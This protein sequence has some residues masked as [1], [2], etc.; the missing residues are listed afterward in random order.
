MDL[1]AIGG[2]P[3][4]VLE[5]L[6]LLVYHLLSL[7]ITKLGFR[8]I[9]DGYPVK[10]N[11]HFP[12]HYHSEEPSE[13]SLDKYEDLIRNLDV[14]AL[15]VNS[16][17][18][19][20]YV[21]R[22]SDTLVEFEILV[23]VLHRIAGQTH[24]ATSGP[25]FIIGRRVSNLY[26]RSY[27]ELTGYC[28]AYRDTM[29]RS[30]ERTTVGFWAETHI[31]GGVVHFDRGETGAE[32]NDVYIHPDDGK[33]VLHKVSREQVHQLLESLA[34]T[35]SLVGES[36][37]LRFPDENLSIPI[38]DAQNRGIYRRKNAANAVIYN[39]LPKGIHVSGFK[40]CV[41]SEE[42]M[43]GKTIEPAPGT[44]KPTGLCLTPELATE[45]GKYW[46]ERN[47]TYL[48]LG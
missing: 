16:E 27:M 5:R 1:E 28:Y 2:L 7:D 14:S 3:P 19:R 32:I 13:E 24:R 30:T 23:D 29:T 10:T 31:F 4:A 22:S 6:G 26:H 17:V 34:Q 8:Q 9:L 47:A 48:V 25:H 37:L 15:E 21:N 43:R 18:L 42:E 39:L 12:S 45:I 36:L 11:C 41:R 38:A 44:H 40:K 20:R 46:A 33:N 35:P